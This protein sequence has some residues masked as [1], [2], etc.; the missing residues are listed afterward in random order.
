L[1]HEFHPLVTG[2]GGKCQ[3]QIMRTPLGPVRGRLWGNRFRIE[4]GLRAVDSDAFSTLSA[5]IGV[6]M[7]ASTGAGRVSH[8]LKTHLAQHPKVVNAVLNRESSWLEVNRTGAPPERVVKGFR[9][10]GKSFFTMSFKGRVPAFR[11]SFLETQNLACLRIPRAGIFAFDIFYLTHPDSWSDRILARTL[12]RGLADYPFILTCSDYSRGEISERFG[13]SPDRIQVVPLDCDRAIFAPHTI[14][15][16]AWLASHALPQGRKVLAHVSSGD[17][18]KNLPGILKAFRLVL[19]KNP[20]AIFVK[21][22]KVLHGSN[23]TDLLTLISTMGLK[24]KVFFL[25]G[26]KDTD[27]ADLYNAADA[28]VFPSLAEGFGIPVLE[29]QACGCPVV[30]ANT[31]SL[32][33]IAGPLS[34][35]VDPTDENAI[36]GAMDAILRDATFRVRNFDA[37]QVFL[38]KFNYA[39]AR[40][41]VADWLL[42]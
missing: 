11:K 17:K 9:K 1:A 33:E 32:R 30:T 31:T 4:K 41:A 38:Q 21:A 39:P 23:H 6:G 15:K 24:D 36:A 8:M 40:K 28:F 42:G 25:E 34:I 7:S 18:R 10:A 27:L 16:A 35:A 22:G 26:L 12:Y 13:I 3:Y 29:A 14:D 2:Y 20:E 5:F 37:S 19:E